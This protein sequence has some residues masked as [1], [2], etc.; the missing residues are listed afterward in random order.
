MQ[1]GL[2]HKAYNLGQKPQ[3]ATEL[4]RD[5][6]SSSVPKV[7]VQGKFIGGYDELAT[8]AENGQLIPMLHQQSMV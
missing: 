1:M 8:L 5:T 6:G 2:P 7:F 3:L 4:A